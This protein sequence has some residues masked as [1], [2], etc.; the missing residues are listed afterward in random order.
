MMVKYKVD[1]LIFSQ[2]LLI[3]LKNKIF[4]IVDVGIDNIVNVIIEKIIKVNQ[5]M[6]KLDKKEFV[7]EKLL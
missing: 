3:V 7:F 2:G 5:S 6:K 4:K 1:W